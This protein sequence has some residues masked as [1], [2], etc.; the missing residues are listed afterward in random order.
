[1]AVN[2]T[3]CYSK[4]L[5]QGFLY[6]SDGSCLG[7]PGYAA[8]SS[9]S[10]P[11]QPDEEVAKFASSSSF[12]HLDEAVQ[13]PTVSSS[14]PLFP[15]TPEREGEK[16][17][18]SVGGV[19][20]GGGGGGLRCGF[21][22]LE[23]FRHFDKTLYHLIKKEEVKRF[24]KGVGTAI[25]VG[26]TEVGSELFVSCHDSR[27]SSKEVGMTTTMTKRAYASWTLNH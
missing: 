8:S 3:N 22:Q 14:S 16:K 18:S 24:I 26:Y 1:M 2:L 17:N 10:F 27:Y 7:P 25:V 11:S 15:L 9:P 6:C 23:C 20:V 19:E 21:D 5:F 4:R 13:N 12:T